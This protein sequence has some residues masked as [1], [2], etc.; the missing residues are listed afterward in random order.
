MRLRKRR[1]SWRTHIL[2]LGRRQR[3]IGFVGDCQGPPIGFNKAFDLVERSHAVRFSGT[4][5]GGMYVI[6]PSPLIR[7]G[8]SS[9]F[10]PFPLRAE[11]TSLRFLTAVATAASVASDAS[12]ISR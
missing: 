8:T 9:F 1:R 11:A 3:L 2:L 5:V 12:S 4:S 7:P 6:P 10:H